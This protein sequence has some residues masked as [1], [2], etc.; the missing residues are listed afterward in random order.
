MK[1][2]VAVLIALAAATLTFAGTAAH[3]LNGASI[4][5]QDDLFPAA[6]RDP[7]VVV[8]AIDDR[9]LAAIGRWPWDRSVHARLLH[10]I[11][12][13][14]ASSVGYDVAFSEP[15]SSRG[16]DDLASA[17]R[18]GHNVVLA[19]PAVISGR[20]GA[21]PRAARF[22]TPVPVLASAAASVAHTNV[23]PDPDGVVRTLPP[24][25]EDPRGDFV[26]ALSFDLY[27]RLRGASGPVTIRPDAVDV[28]RTAVPTGRGHLMTLNFARTPFPTYSAIDVLNGRLPRGALKGKVVLVGATAIGLGDTKLT[29]VDKAEGAPGVLVHANALNTM[30]TGSY[31]FPAGRS[32]NAAAAGLLA[33][34]VA[35]VV[36]YLPVTLAALLSAGLGV[37]YGLYVFARFD[38]GRVYDLVYPG[39]ALAFAYVAA[40]AFR[41][42]TEMRQRRRVS[43]LFGQY[44]PVAVASELVQGRRLRGVLDGERLDVS[45]LFCDLRGFTP[46]SASLE[47]H[48]VKAILD[49]Y[50]RY[51]T[52]L[53]HEHRGTVMQYV[54]DEVFAVF[55]AP[56]P[57]ADHAQRAFECACAFQRTAR[58]I[59]AELESHGIPRI[60]YGVGVNSG[61]V[62][63]AHVGNEILRQYTVV[64]DTVNV[65]ARLCSTARAGEVVI[66]EMVLAEIARPDALE[67]LG[68][69]PLK[70]VSREIK[71][72]RMPPPAGYAPDVIELPAEPDVEET[73]TLVR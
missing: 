24:V 73:P 12:R 11:E 34:V 45:V 70:G 29:P 46:L 33:L 3:V 53:V 69:V 40:L 28:D 48:Q 32:T 22:E 41:Y 43:A 6:G 7:R 5:V 60:R 47:P 63:A 67:D 61:T 39:I 27:L 19:A 56:V 57:S 72:Y 30:L 9:S 62:V 66:S 1:P 59:N 18:E 2:L 37:V 68:A 31:L 20:L 52:R 23:V 17:I 38:G 54:G 16:D 55:G 21:I 8:V 44:V 25:I 14:G 49:V 4:G 35:L 10:A 51:T 26:P 15:G 71:V 13:A 50:Y 36:L 64:G 58:D 42:V 65:G